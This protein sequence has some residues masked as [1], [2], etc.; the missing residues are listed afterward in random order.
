MDRRTGRQIDGRTMGG[1]YKEQRATAHMQSKSTEKPG[2]KA[3]KVGTA[4]FRDDGRLV[5]RLMNSSTD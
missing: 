4:A 2:L 1:Y 5:Y 3:R